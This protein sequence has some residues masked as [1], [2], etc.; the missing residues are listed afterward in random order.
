VDFVQHYQ[1]LIVLGLTAGI[2]VFGIVFRAQVLALVA[3]KANGQAVEA[4]ASQLRMHD[5]RLITMEAAIRHLPTADQMISLTLTV[6]ELRG[7]VREARAEVK[8]VKEAVGGL[9]HRF[10]LVDEHL[11]ARD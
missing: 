11:K 5:Q 7:D 6:S 10:D 9:T 4:V 8:G 3:D 1:G 2:A